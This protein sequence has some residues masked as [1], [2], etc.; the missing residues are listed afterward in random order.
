MNIE[1]KKAGSKTIICNR[2]YYIEPL[3]HTEPACQ[4]SSFFIEGKNLCFVRKCVGFLEKGGC[5]MANP[6]K[7]REFLKKIKISGNTLAVLRIL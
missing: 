5:K 6:E 1:G 4:K 2:R 3:Y 7:L